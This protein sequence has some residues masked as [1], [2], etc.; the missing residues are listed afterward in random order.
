MALVR[1]LA[2]FSRS[3]GSGSARRKVRLLEQVG[4]ARLSP[5]ALVALSD[6]LCFLRAYPDDPS[7]LCAVDAAAGMLR[8][9]VDPDE[10]ALLNSGVPGSANSY[11]YSY[12]VLQRMVRLCPG[13]LEV[14]W[15]E[16]EDHRTLHH[17]LVLFLTVG[18]HQ[19]L[20]DTS[21][22]M[23]AW[24]ERCKKNPHQTDLE[25]LLRLFERDHLSMEE[26]AYLFE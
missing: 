24:V 19:G 8:A 2:E 7:V 10:P 12:G 20:D 13:C 17:A 1:E 16:M 3:F 15:N 11:P 14:D 18:E 22:S 9:R 5:K 23:P 6:T 4:G 21:M 25:F 26:Q